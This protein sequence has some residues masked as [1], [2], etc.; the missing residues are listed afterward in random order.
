MLY[1][2]TVQSVGCCLVLADHEEHREERRGEMD[3]NMDP[4]TTERAYHQE[5][6]SHSPES[7]CITAL[8]AV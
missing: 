4:V 2:S 5:A 7:H 1:A 8:A 6:E 3:N